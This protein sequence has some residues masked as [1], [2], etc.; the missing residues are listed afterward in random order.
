MIEVVV[1]CGE[2]VVHLDGGG[3]AVVA[4][5]ALPLLLELIVAGAVVVD[6]TGIADGAVGIIEAVGGRLVAVAVGP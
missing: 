2:V 3:W 6:E 1:E 5:D 4:G